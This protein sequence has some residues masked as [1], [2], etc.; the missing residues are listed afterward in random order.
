MGF[1]LQYD[2]MH[3]VRICEGRAQKIECYCKGL[4]IWSLARLKKKCDSACVSKTSLPLFNDQKCQAHKNNFKMN[5]I[6]E[7]PSILFFVLCTY[8]NQ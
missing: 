3:S 1:A 5:G 8:V 6:K 2:E 4:W 7:R